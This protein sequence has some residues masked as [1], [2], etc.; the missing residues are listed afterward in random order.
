MALIIRTVEVGGIVKVRKE[1]FSGIEKK[2]GGIVFHLACYGLD[3]GRE[4]KTFC[5]SSQAVSSKSDEQLAVE[6]AW[7]SK[8]L[9]MNET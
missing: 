3:L 5:N 7:A 8:E 4:R 6:E 1:I 9:L 2:N